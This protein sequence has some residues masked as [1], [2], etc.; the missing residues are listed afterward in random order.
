MFSRTANSPAPATAR[1]ILAG[2]LL[3]L[4]LVA[5][6]AAWAAELVVY[7]ARK[8]ALMAPVIET[9]QRETGIKV[10]LK[11]GGGGGL[12][13]QLIEERSNPRADVF[14]TIYAPGLSRLAVEGVLLPYTSPA[15]QKI[16][17]EFR[18]PDAS[19]TGVTGRT[20]VIMYNTN[21]VKAEELPKS[22]LE[23]ADPKWKGKIASAGIANDSMQAHIAALMKLLGEPTTEQWLRGLVANEAKFF[24]GHTEVRKGVG[25]GEFHLGL[26]NDYY[27]YLEKAERSPVGV[28]YPDQGLNDMGVVM[29]MTGVAI[30]RGTKNPEAAQK[31][32]DYLMTSKA[33]QLFAQTNFEIP[34]LPGIKALG[35]ER[36][37]DALKI[38]AY[39]QNRVTGAE[40]DA[41]IKLMT[42]AGVK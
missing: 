10:V 29:T 28:V 26:V 20:R 24:K 2:A 21:L 15:T 4:M 36:S 33:Q 16:P 42:R 25:L 17:A 19:W 35:V 1:P 32:V 8:D 6:A 39:P 27:Y 38:A 3:T 22:V 31:F 40:L 5:P 9:F 34:L 41:A 30:V 23:L 7:S 12:A 37:L 13:N 11:S 18:A 14:V